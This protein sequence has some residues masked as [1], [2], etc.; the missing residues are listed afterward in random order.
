MTEKKEAPP[1]PPH[2]Q[3]PIQAQVDA[4]R[5]LACRYAAA[6]RELAK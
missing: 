4:A 3:A 5:D 1:L 2:L 6:L